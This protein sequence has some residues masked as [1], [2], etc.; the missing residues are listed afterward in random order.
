MGSV[1]EKVRKLFGLLQQRVATRR[2]LRGFQTYRQEL[3]YTAH[4]I[5]LA[6]QELDEVQKHLDQQTE[7]LHRL[8]QRYEEQARKHLK[9]K[10]RDLAEAA[11]RQRLKDQQKLEQW[12]RR[13]K[14]S[15]ERLGIV[16][17]RQR[18]LEESDQAGNPL[19]DELMELQGTLE[20]TREEIRALKV[21]LGNLREWEEGA[22]PAEQLSRCGNC[23]NSL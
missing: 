18:K 5:A 13:V 14:E 9:L 16:R 12:G 6:Q 19:L 23:K 20:H 1:W 8:A 11:I 10:H 15:R 21:Q 2:G 17:V 22:G 3:S 4:R 7:R